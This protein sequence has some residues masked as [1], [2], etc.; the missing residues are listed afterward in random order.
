MHKLE[1]LHSMP[2]PPLISTIRFHL[3]TPSPFLLLAVSFTALELPKR[4]RATIETDVTRHDTGYV[5]F[6]HLGHTRLCKAFGGAAHYGSVT[7]YKKPHFCVVYDTGLNEDLTGNQLAPLLRVNDAALADPRRWAFDWTILSMPKVQGFLPLIASYAASFGLSLPTHWTDPASDDADTS[8]TNMDTAAAFLR[9]ETLMLTSEHKRSFTNAR[10]PRTVTNYKYAALKLVWFA[11]SHGWSLPPTADEF[12]LYLTKL[13]LIRDNAGA[14][15][16]ARNALK[17]I[18]SLN[19]VDGSIYD[20]LRV[21]A[22]LE[23]T[24]R[25]HRHVAKK[26]AALTPAMVEAINKVYSY[27]RPQ[28]PPNKQWE[29]ALGAAVSAAFKLLARHDDAEKLRWNNGFCDVLDTHVRFYLHSRKN[30][31]HGSALLDVARPTDNNPNGVYF[32]LARAKEFF[33]TG[34]VLPHIDRSTGIVDSS[35]PMPYYDYV[36]FLRSA[37]VAIGLSEVQAALFAGHSARAGGATAAAAN[38]LHQEDIQHLAGV[39]SPTW[40]ACY[41]RRHLDEGLRVSR[42]LGL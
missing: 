9:T 14:L 35:R 1:R 11:L 42:S 19:S 41:N 12:G 5:G 24:R 20:T 29:F 13:R 6:I 8:T 32:L 2:L 26:S 38:G 30:L 36:A 33:Q 37:L 27:E 10:A 7:T 31:Q 17:L 34:H 3:S 23:Q 25:E 22:P 28:R 15:D 40:L 16:V 18:C 4:K 21:L 39:V